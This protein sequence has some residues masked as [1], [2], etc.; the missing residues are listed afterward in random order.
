M[1]RLFSSPLVRSPIHLAAFCMIA[2]LQVETLPAQTGEEN[3]ALIDSA[4]RMVNRGDAERARAIELLTRSGEFESV[5]QVLSSIEASKE[6]TEAIAAITEAL[7]PAL[8]LRL[9][10]REDLSEKSQAVLIQSLKAQRELRESPATLD[11]AIEQLGQPSDDSKLGAARTLLKGGQ[12]SIV[13]IVG[14]MMSDPDAA[15]SRDL[16]RV[17]GQLGAGGS[18]ALIQ[19][20]V[21]GDDKTRQNAMTALSRLEH[22]LIDAATLSNLHAEDSSAR[23]RAI[24]ARLAQSR[25]GRLP[26]RSE[27]LAALEVMLDREIDQANRFRND[28][29]VVTAWTLNTNDNSVSSVQTSLSL[30]ERR[31]S[32]DVGAMM[33][34]VGSIGLDRERKIAVADLGYRMAVD[35]DW[36]DD[37]QADAAIE[38]FPWLA[39]PL[40]VLATL[41]QA[42]EL[43]DL[44]ATL[45]VLRLI[46]ADRV[47]AAGV[48]LVHSQPAP[49]AL[50]QLASSSIARVRYEA[51][52]AI[53]AT[54]MDEPY[55]GSS[56]VRR[57][58]AEMSRLGDRP[59]VVLIETRLGVR[60]QLSSLLSRLGF[61]VRMTG[62]AQEALRIVGVSG[63]DVRFVLA[64]TRLSDLAPI[65]LVDR[66][67]RLEVGHNV[68]IVFYL[69]DTTANTDLSWLDSPRWPGLT[70]AINLPATPSGMVPVLQQIEN[71][72]TVTP[73]S[74]SD[75]S[76]F[77]EIGSRKM[78]GE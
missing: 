51:A 4:F 3:S 18:D 78:N 73:L 28:P 50:V 55:A 46:Q 49:S 48:L 27:S 42:I 10:A 11:Q 75:R 38:A 66:I 57:T 14:H 36:G 59:I 7:G 52:A 61:S 76:Q 53:A 20:A 23:L 58:F 37:G 31:D 5:D 25:F 47:D 32:V 54:G 12:A 44:A 8:V 6:T 26:E 35:P 69:G 63:S 29:S 22:P 39:D 30:A 45:P 41:E 71:Q 77:R 56:T 24:A 15:N 21:Y 34:R 13:R 17:L 65:E 72:Q 62:S 1:P 33:R 16:L 40:T 9:Q 43:D 74:E 2:M 60:S 19:L 67:R 70:T 68:P 64:K